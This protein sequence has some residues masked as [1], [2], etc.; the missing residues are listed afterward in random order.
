MP[1]FAAENDAS[2]EYNDPWHNP[3]RIDPMADITRPELD[4]KLEAVEARMETRVTR[5]ENKIDIAVEAIRGAAVESKSLRNTILALIV[6]VIVTAVGTVVGVYGA[7]ASIVQSVISAFQ[8]GQQ[9][10]PNPQAKKAQ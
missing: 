5:I 7:N 6:T 1:A 9:S 3:R 8:A 10:T 2:Y 4:A